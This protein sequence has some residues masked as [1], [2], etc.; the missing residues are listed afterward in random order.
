MNKNFS[1]IHFFK[2]LT[3]L[4]IHYFHIFSCQMRDE[5]ALLADWVD[6][7][8]LDSMNNSKI[9][10]LTNSAMFFQLWPL[11]YTVPYEKNE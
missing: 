11:R 2:Y 10:I 8:E 4:H 1:V 3:T 6:K 9:A 7:S 5:V